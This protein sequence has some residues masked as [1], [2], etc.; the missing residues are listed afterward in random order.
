M[1][2]KALKVEKKSAKRRMKL[3]LILETSFFLR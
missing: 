3:A 2:G 1:L